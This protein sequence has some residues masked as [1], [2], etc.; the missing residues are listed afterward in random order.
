VLL[1]A[2]FPPLSRAGAH[3]RG[4]APRIAL[5]RTEQW[6][7]ADKS[8]Q[9]IVEEIAARL[10]HAGAPVVEL[11]LGPAFEG[12]AGAHRTIMAAEAARV[13][14]PILA[15]HGDAVS[16]V[17]RDFVREGERVGAE[18]E[19]AARGQAERCRELLSDVFAQVDVLLTPSVVGEAPLGLE[20]TG[21]PAFNRIWTLLGMPCVSLPAARGPAGMP[22][23][24]QL[25]GA[26]GADAALVASAEWVERALGA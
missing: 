12:L 1:G 5:C 20:S 23:G 3:P 17:L 10:A 13:F 7:L 18:R 26:R 19:D 15:R 25:V 11:D 22:V 21:D 16:A 14:A 9:R 2:L 8:T 6:P 4:S 24:V